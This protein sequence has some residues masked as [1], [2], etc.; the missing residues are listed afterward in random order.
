MK[1]AGAGAIRYVDGWSRDRVGPNGSLSNGAAVGMKS[2]QLGF[3]NIAQVT[4]ALLEPMGPSRVAALATGLTL[5]I[6]H[7][8]FRAVLEEFCCRTF[9]LGFA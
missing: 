6:V 7:G 4:G 9:A 3:H 1:N 5:T 8:M 2:D